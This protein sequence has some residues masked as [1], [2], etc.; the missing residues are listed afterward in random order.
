MPRQI[1]SGLGIKLENEAD[2]GWNCD[3]MQHI[4]FEFVPEGERRIGKEGGH[5]EV[6]SVRR[7]FR[8][9]QVQYG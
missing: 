8:A 1:Y 2:A 3:P 7:V 9:V 4:K 5:L 6:S